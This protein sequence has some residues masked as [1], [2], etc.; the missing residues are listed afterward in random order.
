[1]AAPC[2]GMQKKA[3]PL[4]PPAPRVQ[5]VQGVSNGK[6]TIVAHTQ[7]TTSANEVAKEAIQAKK[8]ARYILK[9]KG[10]IDHFS[11]LFPLVICLLHSWVSTT[12]SKL[13]DFCSVLNATKIRTHLNVEFWRPST[14]RN[15]T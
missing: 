2:P 5:G 14:T 7:H 15:S 3:H 13:L 11:T 10:F 8:G 9:E 1:M 12:L 6:V 4:Q